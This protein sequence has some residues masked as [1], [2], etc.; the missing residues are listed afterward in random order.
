MV[1]DDVTRAEI[2]WALHGIVTHSSL[3]DR[4]SAAELFP[5]IFLDNDIAKKV[6]LHKDK[7][8][9]LVTYELAPHFQEHWSS[10][11]LR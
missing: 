6:K 1:R 4:S 7:I 10:C 2:I 8:T 9:Y 3:R 11:H 5:L